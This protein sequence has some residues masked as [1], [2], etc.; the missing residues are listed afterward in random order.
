VL[1]QQ[2]FNIADASRPPRAPGPPERAEVH[3]LRHRALVAKGRAIGAILVDNQFTRRPITDHDM[4]FLTMF[5]HQAA[6]A[7][8]N[9]IIHSNMEAMN[10]DIRAMK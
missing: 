4:R 6:L 1:E 7:I 9:A 2:A 8:D 5:A 3:Q 10:R